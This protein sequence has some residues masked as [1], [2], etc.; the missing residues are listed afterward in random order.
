MA[1]SM[2]PKE[3]RARM[4]SMRGLIQ[5]FNVYRWAGRM[6]MDAAR[7]RRRIRVMKQV[8]QASGRGR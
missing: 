8:G 4:R 3:Q 7:M 1:L 6:L 5:E 2:T